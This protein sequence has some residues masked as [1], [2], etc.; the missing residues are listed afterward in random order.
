MKAWNLS[1]LI[2]RLRYLVNSNEGQ[3]DQDFAGPS[4]DADRH[5]RDA[6]NEA[7]IEEVTEAAQHADPARWLHAT[8][9]FTW[10]ASE[11]TLT[12]PPAIDGKNLLGLQDITSSTPGTPLWIGA[13]NTIWW[14]DR[15]T[16]QWGS[17]GPASDTTIL[18]TYISEPQELVSGADEPVL[19]PRAHRHLLVWSA[20][21]IMRSI[22]DEDAP[23]SWMNKR[24]ELR[25]ALWKDLSLGRPMDTGY[26]GILTTNNDYYGPVD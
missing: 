9:T 1:Q 7:Y 19:I 5:F 2:L 15:T 20:G 25:E 11:P 26:P 6:L 17:T 23:G 14:K 4:G 18:A 12:L 21:C 16:L 13:A 3:S 8:H 10:E 24:D 22:A